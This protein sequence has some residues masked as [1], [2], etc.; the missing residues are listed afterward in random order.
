[1]GLGVSLFSFRPQGRRPKT[2]GFGATPSAAIAKPA[3]SAAKRG[4]WIGPPG[5]GHPRASA[6]KGPSRNGHLSELGFCRP[7]VGPSGA[8]GRR[9]P[10][11]DRKSPSRAYPEPPSCGSI[12]VSGYLGYPGFWRPQG[13]AAHPTAVRDR[14]P[15]GEGPATCRASPP[16]PCAGWARIL[17]PTPVR[18]RRSRPQGSQ[19]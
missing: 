2:P 14:P 1:M 18:W 10:A 3:D 7:A 12:S 11:G 16:G 15:S 8:S 19:G 9:D 5:P 4:F 13:S 17:P 6:R